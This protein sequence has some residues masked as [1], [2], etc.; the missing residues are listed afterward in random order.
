MFVL[1]SSVYGISTVEPRLQKIQW[2]SRHLQYADILT[3]Y[4]N[5]QQQNSHP[6]ENKPIVPCQKNICNIF[7]F[8]NHHLQCRW[9]ST[10][11]LY[12][13]QLGQMITL[14]C[15]IVQRF[16]FELTCHR[17]IIP[18]ICLVSKFTF[19]ACMI[20]PSFSFVS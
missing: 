2:G 17:A 5:A 10:V 12:I 1:F 13:G 16:K 7:A 14:S 15:E 8:Q 20:K 9:G 6:T 3:F 18:I 19:T 11:C 4:T